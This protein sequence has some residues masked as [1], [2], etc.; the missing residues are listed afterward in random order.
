MA[1]YAL[2]NHKKIS[3][4]FGEKYL[5]LLLKSLDNHFSTNEIIEEKDYPSEKLK[6]IWVDNV[7][8]NTD[9]FFEF[10]V[11]GK[12]FDVYRLAYK[13]AAG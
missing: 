5:K 2:R 13:G 4:A 9:S 1:R 8:P 6:V 11:I 10:Y 12:T 3:N 7:Q